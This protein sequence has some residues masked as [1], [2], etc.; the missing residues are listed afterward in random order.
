[1]SSFSF[2]IL[3]NQE[4]LPCLKEM[5]LPLTAEQLAK[6]TYEILFRVYEMLVTTLLGV[7]RSVLPELAM[8]V[9]VGLFRQMQPS[10]Y[11]N[12]VQNRT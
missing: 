7:S 11:Q 4:L 9:A 12:S 3:S 5:E 2:P 8:L 10:T 1:M 6:P